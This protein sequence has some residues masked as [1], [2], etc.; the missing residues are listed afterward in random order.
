MRERK[1][2]NFKCSKCKKQE[3]VEAAVD[4]N[5]CFVVDATWPVGWLDVYS[6]APSLEAGINNVFCDLCKLPVLQALGYADYKDYIS[7]VKGNTKI[8][9]SFDQVSTDESVPFYLL[10]EDGN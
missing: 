10:D 9:R 3:F 4:D 5:G 2:L 8:K 1:F 6:C 7:V